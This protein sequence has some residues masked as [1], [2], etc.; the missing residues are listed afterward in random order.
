MCNYIIDKTWM[1]IVILQTELDCEIVVFDGTWL[2][3]DFKL[4]I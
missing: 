4:K 1:R 2:Q 3:H